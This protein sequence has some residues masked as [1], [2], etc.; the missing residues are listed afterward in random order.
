M[1]RIA[2]MLLLGA[3][4]GVFAPAV[5]VSAASLS[6]QHAPVSFP[7]DSVRV[8]MVGVGVVVAVGAELGVCVGVGVGGDTE[9][10]KSIV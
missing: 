1:K 4:A 5:S 10:P 2:G 3:L 9:K 6:R 7:V 8:G